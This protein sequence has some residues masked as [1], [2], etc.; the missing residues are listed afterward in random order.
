M[1]IGDPK[2]DTIEAKRRRAI[3][4]KKTSPKKYSPGFFAMFTTTPTQA[5]DR[6]SSAVSL[7]SNIFEP[8]SKSAKGRAK[9]K[10]T[11][12]TTTVSDEQKASS[13]VRK[14]SSPVRNGERD[15]FKNKD[16]P[17]KSSG[18]TWRDFKSVA[19]ARKAGLNY[20]TGKDGKKKIAITAEQLKKKGMT[21]REYANSIK[22]KK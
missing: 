2:T 6:R 14:K 12:R 16:A 8:S 1:A 11:S 7:L 4:Y 17:S 15:I 22:G 18:K 5:A 3:K 9:A 20:F 19:A 13:Q 10:E 21:L